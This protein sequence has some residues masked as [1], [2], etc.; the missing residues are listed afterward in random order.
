VSAIEES[1]NKNMEFFIMK[2]EYNYQFIRHCFDG[3]RLLNGTYPGSISIVLHNV[4]IGSGWKQLL[5]IIFPHDT[6]WFPQSPKA[7]D[8]DI[9]WTTYHLIPRG[10]QFGFKVHKMTN[11]R[12]FQQLPH[13][14]ASFCPNLFANTLND[15]QLQT[16]KYVTK[17]NQRFNIGDI[18]N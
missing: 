3:G 16:F 4:T 6:S 10:L 18:G 8:Y 1:N 5:S 2:K 14:H 9:A 7:E 11:K 17:G 12:N 13:I 15:I